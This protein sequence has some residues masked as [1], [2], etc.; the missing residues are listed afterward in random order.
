MAFLSDLI[1]YSFL[2]KLDC[3]AYRCVQLP[4]QNIYVPLC[5]FDHSAECVPHAWCMRMPDAC[6]IARHNFAVWTEHGMR[7]VYVYMVSHA[8]AQLFP[9]PPPQ[10]LTTFACSSVSALQEAPHIANC[11]CQDSKFAPHF[12]LQCPPISQVSFFILSWIVFLRGSKA[13]CQPLMISWNRLSR[14]FGAR[15]STFGWWHQRSDDCCD[16]MLGGNTTRTM[17]LAAR[18]V[19][20]LLLI[21]MW[22]HS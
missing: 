8:S 2:V 11:A 17:Q 4:T 7:C 9:Q 6:P 15:T 14:S 3:C 19:L 5:P 18:M 22:W 13:L 10:L 12:V 20:A 1:S 16:C 21:F